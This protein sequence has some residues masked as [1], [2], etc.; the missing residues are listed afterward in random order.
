MP[1]L[2]LLL[3][4][5]YRTPPC[6]LL[7][8]ASLHT[9]PWCLY[10]AG[11]SQHLPSK[12]LPQATQGCVPS[13]LLSV[14]LAV[15]YNSQAGRSAQESLEPTPEPEAAALSCDLFCLLKITLG[16]DPA[17]GSRVLHDS[18]PALEQNRP[19]KVLLC[20]LQLYSSLSVARSA[21]SKEK[22]QESPGLCF[23]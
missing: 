18:Q 15:C 20:V 21:T 13:V 8:R 4:P 16:R 2:Q 22:A 11:T 6:S 19:Y 7:R 9:S 10:P 3:L 23:L 12:F 5:F 17:S 1:T 14:Y